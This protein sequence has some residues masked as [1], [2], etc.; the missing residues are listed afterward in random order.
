VDDSFASA[1]AILERSAGRRDR[2]SDTFLKVFPVAGAAVSTLGDVLGSEIVSASNPTAGRLDEL[3]L[4]LGEGPCWDALRSGQPIAEPDLMSATATQRW[5]SFA[6]AARDLSAASIFAF[7]VAV[8]PLRLG[9]VDLFAKK[10]LELSPLQARQ[11]TAMAKVIGRHLLGAAIESAEEEHGQRTSRLSRRV[12]HQAT[13]VV[14]AQLNTSPEDAESLIQAHAFANG[15]A[16]AE[17]AT[18]I[19]EGRL[20]F[21]QRDGE[22]EAVE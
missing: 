10:R 9:A 22:I 15:R 21:R 6:A 12:I 4:D 7:P 14:L 5:P 3:Q 2:Y 8:G 19:I 16:M 11:A 18:D 20:R 17:V 1:L 13:G